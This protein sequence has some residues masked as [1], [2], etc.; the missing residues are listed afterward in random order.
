MQKIFVLFT[1]LIA[2]AIE[3][4]SL[5]YSSRKYYA[6]L[7]PRMKLRSLWKWTVSIV[8]LRWGVGMLSSLFFNQSSTTATETTEP[9]TLACCLSPRFKD[10]KW[11]SV[12]F[13]SIGF[14]VLHYAP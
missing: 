13:A 14:A 7:F 3:G 9:A 1:M 2:G 8:L 12:L 6:N 10:N 11:L 5:P 4:T